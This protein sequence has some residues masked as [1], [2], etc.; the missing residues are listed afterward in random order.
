MNSNQDKFKQV[1][2][3]FAVALDHEDYPSAEQLLAPDCQYEIK[4]DRLS[5]PA[6]I[7]ASYK[8]NGDDAAKRFDRIEYGSAV[9]HM[10]ENQY[11]ITFSDDIEHAGKRCFYRCEQYFT[12]SKQGLIEAIRHQEIPG[13]REA[14]NQFLEEVGLAKG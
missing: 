3:K 2:E 7:I 14:L 4:G 10:D 11:V 1:V 8:G 13:E 6:A 5:G 12:V 9:R